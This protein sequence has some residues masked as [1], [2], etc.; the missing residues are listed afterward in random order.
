MSCEIARRLMESGES[1]AAIQTHTASC[2]SCA[3]GENTSYYE[4][5]AGLEE[6]IRAS[7]ATERHR[8]SRRNW[9]AAAAVAL[10]V[11]SGTLTVD[12]VRQSGNAMETAI[13]SAHLRSL[14]GTHLLD[15][16]SSDQHTV[17]PWFNGKLDFSPAVPSF[18]DF[19]LLG[20]R[21]E[22]FEAHPA[23]A[24]IYD[25]GQHMIN[26]FIWH[27]NGSTLEKTWTSNGYHVI[28]WAKD[29]MNYCAVSDV[30]AAELDRF[31]A[32]YRAN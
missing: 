16:P 19:P 30:N 14:E 12:L 23:A 26:L 8:P 11:V 17:K 24:L 6:K 21:L 32:L 29:R 10:L 25:R 20:G 9:W 1:A 4:A 27:V 13:L 15:V 22:Y 28:C 18:P 31:A 3:I 2:L 7:L 5:P